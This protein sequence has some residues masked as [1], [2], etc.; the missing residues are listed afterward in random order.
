MK[1]VWRSKDG[2]L[3]AISRVDDKIRRHDQLTLPMTL[4]IH[5]IHDLIQSDSASVSRFDPDLKN[6]L[7]PF[8]GHWSGP[9]SS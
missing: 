7:F 9:Y 1:I 2:A 3:A 5:S 6:V 8:S 4:F